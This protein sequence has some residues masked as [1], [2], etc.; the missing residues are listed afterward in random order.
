MIMV[1]Q[2]S[3]FSTSMVL[4]SSRSSLPSFTKAI[5][6]QP[7]AKSSTMPTEPAYKPTHWAFSSRRAMDVSPPHSVKMRLHCFQ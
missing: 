7:M 4:N 5:R 6:F 3:F 2:A 1:T